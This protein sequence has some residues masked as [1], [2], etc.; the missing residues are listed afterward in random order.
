VLIG[1]DKDNKDIGVSYAWTVNTLSG[2]TAVAEESATKEFLTLQPN[3]EGRWEV[4]V[5]VTGRNFVDGETV[6][7]TATT[8]V[9]CDPAAEPAA[10][11]STYGPYSG[12]A[13][14]NFAP[15]QF[16]EGGNGFGWSLG[17]IGGYWYWPVNHAASYSIPGNS[18][19][20][21]TETTGWVEAGIVWF[22]EDLNGN[23]LPDEVWYEVYG[24]TSTPAVPVT[25]KYSVK[26][27]KAD[28]ANSQTDSGYG[29]QV[30]RGVYW[31]D[32]K[33]RTG[34]ISGGWPHNWGA[35]NYK[36][37][38]VTYT[39]TL[40][41]DNGWIDSTGYGYSV[42]KDGGPYVDHGPYVIPI[43]RAVAAD[44]SPVTLTRV[45]FVKV[46]TAIFRYGSVFGEISTEITH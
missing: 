17:T 8:L 22:Q 37:A 36:G 45:R 24:G 33:G 27:F 32:C 3:N 14:R 31:A 16:T 5:T 12:N 29:G 23:G 42:P 25:R 38:W 11:L 18:F 41:C 1:Y 39:A 21:S 4:S 6:S 7:K 46:H 2:G 15:G 13:V 10:S 30:H 9:I 19:G 40:L 26:F 44:G 20:E 35:P 34:N 28:D 43:S